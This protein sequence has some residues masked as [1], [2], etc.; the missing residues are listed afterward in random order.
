MYIM[1]KQHRKLDENGVETEQSN[2]H[3]FL[4]TNFLESFLF[5][6]YP[7][8]QVYKCKKKPFINKNSQSL[9]T[10]MFKHILQHI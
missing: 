2:R 7:T 6:F 9:S 4:Q 10:Y 5:F 8:A 1:E 3:N